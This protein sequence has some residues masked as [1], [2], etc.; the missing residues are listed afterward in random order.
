MTMHWLYAFSILF[1]Y[2]ALITCDWLCIDYLYTCSHCDYA[3]IICTLSLQLT[4]LTICIVMRLVVDRLCIDYMDSHCDWLYTLLVILHW[5]H[6]LGHCDWLCVHYVHVA[7]VADH[8]DYIDIFTDYIDIFIVTDC[9]N[10]MHVVIV[11]DDV[12]IMCRCI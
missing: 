7:I 11:T 5:L 3:L 6:A 8:T 9:A 4:A 10:Y 1:L 12:F 2:W